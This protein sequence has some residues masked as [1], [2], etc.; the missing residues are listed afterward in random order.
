[1]GAKLTLTSA[2]AR[3]PSTNRAVVMRPYFAGRR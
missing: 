1:M 3:A 2:I